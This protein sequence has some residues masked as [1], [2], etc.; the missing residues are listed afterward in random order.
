[1]ELLE[2]IRGPGSSA[3]G[4]GRSL[5]I[6]PAFLY[7]IAHGK[8]KA[9]AALSRSIE[10]ATRGA[11]MRWDLRPDDWHLIWPELIDTAGAPAIP[12]QQ[13]RTP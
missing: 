9:N 3:A 8:R 5:G 4:L 12:T 2:Y 1:M 10:R 6:A 11:V 13:R 7:Q